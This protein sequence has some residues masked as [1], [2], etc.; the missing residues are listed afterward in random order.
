MSVS[1]AVI[2]MLPESP[3]LSEL[4]AW[5][6]ESLAQLHFARDA[7]GAR[8]VLPGCDYVVVCAR[9]LAEASEEELRALREHSQARWVLLRGDHDGV[10]PS[11]TESLKFD[12]QLQAPR[13]LP[14]RAPVPE[15]A[16]PLLRVGALSLDTRSGELQVGE[17][18]VQ[19]TPREC[20]LLSVFLR[21]PN[22]VLKKEEL[23]E[24]CW[25]EPS[26]HINLV[27]VTIRRLR[28]KLQAQAGRSDLIENCRGFGY[29]LKA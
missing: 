25:G 21:R 12:H 1:A 20:R 17:R 26:H 4:E 27:Q 3:D 11:W 22:Q 2:G 6:G 5:A 24:G 16:E 10:L 29:K 13:P 8:D 28:Q 15:A 19:L 9:H 18:R 7:Q 14:E 23:M